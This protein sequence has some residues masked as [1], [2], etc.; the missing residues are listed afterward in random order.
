[1]VSHFGLVVDGSAFWSLLFGG[2]KKGFLDWVT[3][4]RLTECVLSPISVE[5]ITNGLS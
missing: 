1:M 3:D 2:S 5:E 4:V